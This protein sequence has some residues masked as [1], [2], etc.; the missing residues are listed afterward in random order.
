M[1]ILVCSSLMADYVEHALMYLL[2][3]FIS[4]LVEFLSE[5]FA[6]FRVQLFIFL[7]SNIM[8]SLYILNTSLI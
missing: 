5:S 2:A 6:H 8:S 7:L 1:M 4:C 3:I